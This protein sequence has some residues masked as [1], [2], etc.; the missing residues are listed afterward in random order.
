MR[1]FCTKTMT[2]KTY[3]NYYLTIDAVKTY[4]GG[5]NTISTN[6]TCHTRT[7]KDEHALHAKANTC[8]KVIPA[9]CP[10]YR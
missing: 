3:I 9:F 4:G 1:L 7:N 6:I 2:I 10:F 8:Y 5:R